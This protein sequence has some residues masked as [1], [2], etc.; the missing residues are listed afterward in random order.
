MK[1]VNSSAKWA[2]L[3]LAAIAITASGGALASGGHGGH[4]GG[5]HGGWGHG[6]GGH[7]WHGHGYGGFGFVYAPYWGWGPWYSPYWDSWYGYG[8][9]AYPYYSAYPAVAQSEPPVYVE[10]HA[11]G[12]Y[13]YYC[14]E[15]GGYYP[16]VQNC[17]GGWQKVPPRPAD[18]H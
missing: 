2:V 12:G 17:P 1:S 16:E 13:W 18:L 7:G 11:P 6:G 9:G 15:A 14:N 4:G 3:V 10:Q 5:G 8:Y